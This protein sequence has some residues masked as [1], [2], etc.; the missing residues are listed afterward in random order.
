MESVALLAPFY[1]NSWK[2][3][4]M[5]RVHILC[6]ISIFLLALIP[7]LP[8]ETPRPASADALVRAE[9][10][11][12]SEM[13]RR[14]DSLSFGKGSK[15]YWAY[16]TGVFLKGLDSLWARTRNVNYYDYLKSTMDS[17]LDS[18]GTIKTYR[19]DDYNLDSINCGKLLL[20]LYEST[21]KEKYSKA[22]SLLMK[23]LE[24]Q[25]RTHEGGFWHKKIYPYQMWLDGIYMSS[26]FLAEYSQIFNRPAGLDEVSKQI[27]W[28]ESHTR[29]SQTGL[30]YH[31]WDE[32]RT[33]EWADP[34]TGCS[35]I[36]WG[37]A[38]GWYAMAIVDA[39]DF[40]PKNHRERQR[41]IEIF[42]RMSAALAHYQ[43]SRTGLWYQVVNQGERKGN[44]LEASASSMFVY[45]FAKGV[46]KG[47]LGREYAA[48]A[49][50]GYEGL[51]QHL[52]VAEPDGK[53]SLTKICSVGGLGGP[54][55]RNGTFEYYISEPV[56]TNDLK[57]V[58]AFILAS[59][60][61]DRLSTK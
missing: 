46:R 35:R 14:Q 18:E 7:A 55:K 8:G 25:P 23:Q 60:E 15:G 3:V 41:L 44:Y 34:S 53:L 58:G 31:G 2:G 16:E 20:S 30:L 6:V 59:V 37:R 4:F 39:L 17:F 13:E 29:D 11:A 9:K 32:S 61:I 27:I 28:I 26:P 45:A 57:G 19:L 36:F 47:Y 42:Q 43:D 40:Y 24:K 48:A 49:K 50:K 54:Q 12:S 22:A 5:R 51:I 1:A 10:M 52:V 56:V 21:K 33:Q 38:M